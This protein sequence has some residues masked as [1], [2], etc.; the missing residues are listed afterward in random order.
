MNR[1]ACLVV[2]IGTAL[3]GSGCQKPVKPD[4][5]RPLPPGASALRKILLE[6]HWPD[7]QTAHTKDPQLA[8]AMDRSLGWFNRKSSQRH[9][10][11]LDV[12]YDRAKASVFAFRQILNES[13]TGEVFEKVIKEQF[14]CY[15][16][17]GWDEKG[18]VLYTGYYTPIFRGSLQQTGQFRFPLYKRPADLISD[19][20]TGRILGRKTTGGPQPY[21][22]R[23][24]IESTGMLKGTEL[25]WVESRLDQY[26]I[27][28]NGSARI[29]LPGGKPFFIGYAGTNGREYTGLGS[30]LVKDGEISKEEIGLP[31]I[32]R[33]FREQPQKLERYI[34]RNDRFVFF[35][36][37]PG[38]NWPAGS[39]GVKVATQRSL[40]TDKQIFPRG[41]VVLADTQ[42]PNGGPFIQIMMDQDTGGAIRAPGRADIYMGIG[43]NAEKLAGRQFSEGRLYYFFL[44]MPRIDEWLDRIAQEKKAAKR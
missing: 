38:E 24:Q 30:Q 25:V 14:D 34:S 2:V 4:Y 8:S 22:T 26:I 7:L 17:V 29:D 21:P 10:P 28:V 36:P 44:K 40:A 3:L 18:T 11:I 42:H 9:F 35:G 6:S 43:L 27:Q 37:Y 39:I 19:P 32:R 12:T 15:I 33:Y 13:N 23:A 1:L 20:N 31:A 5:S 16:S 41:G